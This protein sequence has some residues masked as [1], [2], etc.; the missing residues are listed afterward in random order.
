MQG[1]RIHGMVQNGYGMG[2][3]NMDDSGNDFCECEGMT[4][5][6]CGNTECVWYDDFLDESEEEEE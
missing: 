2:D 1:Q 5:G 3:R 6:R 4:C